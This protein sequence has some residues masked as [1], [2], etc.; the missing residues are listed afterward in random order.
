MV[1][2]NHTSI[3]I[4][5]RHHHTCGIRHLWAFDPFRH[6]VKQRRATLKLKDL[7]KH[8]Q[9]K[10]TA[11]VDGQLVARQHVANMPNHSPLKKIE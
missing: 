9:M 4:H 2:I 10:I 5:R 3:P 6:H 11:E 7:K 1:V 8:P